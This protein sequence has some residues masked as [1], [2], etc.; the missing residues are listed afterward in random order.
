MKHT[1]CLILL[2]FLGNGAFSQNYTRDA[3][4]RFMNGFFVSYRQFY[5]EE[6]AIEGFAGFSEKSFRIAGFREFFRPLA[7]IRSQNLRMLYG[8][9]IHAGVSY[10]NKYKIFNREYYHNWVWSPQFGIDGIFGAEYAASDYPI[11]MT[12]AIQPYFE[13][14]I[15][16]FFSIQ[17]FNFIVVFKYR[18]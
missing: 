2:V 3:G 13:Y 9:G 14:S 4:I 10:T 17:P 16:H 7:P 8:Y 11:L 12:A 5:D 1:I 6:R 15:N 18:F